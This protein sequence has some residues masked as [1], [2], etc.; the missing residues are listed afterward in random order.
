MGQGKVGTVRILAVIAA[1]AV[2]APSGTAFAAPSGFFGV[3]AIFSP[4]D[5]DL[6]QMGRA[7]AGV[8]RQ[9]FSWS[10]LEPTPGSLNF[11]N[12]DRVVAG[13]ASQGMTVLPFVYGTP[14]W[15]RNCAGIADFFCDRVTPLR[16]AQG[17]QRWP[18]LMRALVDRYGPNGTLWTDPQDAYS[19]PYQPIRT[20]QIWNEANSGTYFR[21]RPKPKAYY[22]L[23]KS[24]SNAIRSRDQ[25]AQILLAGLFGTPPKPGIPLWNFLDGLY[26]IKKA[27]QLF[28]AVAVNP[29]SP[30]IKGINYQLRRARQVMVEHGDKKTPLYLTEMGWGS[31]GSAKANS[32]YKGL[33]GQSQMLTNSFRFALK[34]RKR[35]RLRGVSWFSWRDLAPGQVGNCLLCESFGLL[36]NDGSAKPALSAFV[37]FTGGQP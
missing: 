9:P 25:G 23:L 28:S 11:A 27:K 19:P 2:M 16:S 14:P 21:P 30:N 4:T 15:A 7:H 20:W 36:A 32:L 18:E 22:Q 12:F 35:Y 31:V 24:A 17:A 37:R 10:E 5:A 26:K 8:V 13:A 1:I 29:Y 33:A 3:T 6:A 34:N